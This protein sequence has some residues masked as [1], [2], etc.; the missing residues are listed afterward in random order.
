MRVARRNAH[1]GHVIQARIRIPRY[2]AGVGKRLRR[3]LP[4]YRAFTYVSTYSHCFTGRNEVRGSRRK[5]GRG[6]R[7]GGKVMEKR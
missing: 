2:L 4:N 1:R 5:S 6:G 7:E 3:I